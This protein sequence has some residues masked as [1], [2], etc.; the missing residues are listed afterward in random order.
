MTRADVDFIRVDRLRSGVEIVRTMRAQWSRL[1]RP[2]RHRRPGVSLDP[3]LAAVPRDAR[4]RDGRRRHRRRAKSPP[5]ADAMA[6]RA[7]VSTSRRGRARRRVRRRWLRVRWEARARHR[8]RDAAMEDALYLARP[9]SP[10]RR[11]SSRRPPRAAH[12][13]ASR[14]LSRTRPSRCATTRRSSASAATP[15]P[16]ARCIEVRLAVGGG[17]EPQATRRRSLWT[18]AASR[19]ATSPRLALFAGG[20]LERDGDG[21][22]RARAAAAEHLRRRRLRR[23]RRGRP[24]VPPGRTSA[25]SGAAAALDAE[26]WLGELEAK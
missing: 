6:R 9:P 12:A 2:R 24:G 1:R 21:Y 22:A 15:R 26:R 11:P 7:G 14:V 20:V 13:L 19:S 4:E 23:R 5:S 18:L 8:R 16:T 10:R 25:G 17:G 3:S